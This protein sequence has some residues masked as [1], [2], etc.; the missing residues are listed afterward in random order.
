MVSLSAA[1]RTAFACA[2]ASS[3]QRSAQARLQE[4]QQESAQLV[5]DAADQAT[6]VADAASRT[7]ENLLAKTQAEAGLGPGMVA[8]DLRL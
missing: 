7:S 2:R 5:A 3:T 4:A 1:S 8:W 6:L